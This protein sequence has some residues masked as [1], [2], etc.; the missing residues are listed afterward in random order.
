MNHF[1][2]PVQSTFLPEI[3]DMIYL[4]TGYGVLLF[5]DIFID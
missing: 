4:Q 2:Q 1:C 5:L 3:I